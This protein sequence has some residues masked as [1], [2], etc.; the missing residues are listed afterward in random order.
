[1][2]KREKRKVGQ[3]DG[4]LSSKLRGKVSPED[5]CSSLVLPC[6]HLKVNDLLMDLFSWLQ[7]RSLAF[8][9]LCA[10]YASTGTFALSA[11]MMPSLRFTD[12]SCGACHASLC[13][14][15]VVEIYRWWWGWGFL[16]G[17]R[18]G[19][20]DIT[21]RRNEPCELWVCCLPEF[22]ENRRRACLE[23]GQLLLLLELEY[24]QRGNLLDIMS[25]GTYSML[26]RTHSKAS[27][28]RDLAEFFLS[29]W[30]SFQGQ[31]SHW[32]LVH[33]WSTLGT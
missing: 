18:C 7:D 22:K 25:L 14:P 4:L 11:S 30:H 13:C 28:L 21:P 24:E 5:G 6:W 2:Q 26:S 20:G 33:Y 10:L 27:F 32:V 23:W 9:E 8:H 31:L 1:M 16:L 17:S 29:E 19:I 12:S 3:V 15:V